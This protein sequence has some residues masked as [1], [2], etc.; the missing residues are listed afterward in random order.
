MFTGLAATSSDGMD[1]AD[2]ATRAELTE[3]KNPAEIQDVEAVLEAF[4]AERAAHP[5]RPPG[6]GADELRSAGSI[7]AVTQARLQRVVKCPGP[8]LQA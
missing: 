2:R 4:A 3:G 7:Q 1:T 6:D 5:R 8:R